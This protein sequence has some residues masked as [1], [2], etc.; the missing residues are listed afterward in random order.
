MYVFDIW[1]NLTASL[2][3]HKLDLMWYSCNRPHHSGCTWITCYP[4]TMTGYLK[5]AHL[6]I[7]YLLCIIFT[8]VKKWNVF[9]YTMGSFIVELHASQLF[10]YLRVVALCPHWNLL[11]KI[12]RNIIFLYES[13]F[14]KRQ[15]GLLN[16]KKKKHRILFSHISVTI[17]AFIIYDVM[18]NI[19]KSLSLS[20]EIWQK[21]NKMPQEKETI[22]ACHFYGIVA[23]FGNPMNRHNCLYSKEEQMFIKSFPESIFLSHF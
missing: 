17:K 19:V 4:V 22:Q 11:Y 9:V 20:E 2:T 6:S 15:R 12:R 10:L 21:N 7:L 3:K 5:Q 8:Y 1:P 16:T 14:I 23:K 18:G 13:I